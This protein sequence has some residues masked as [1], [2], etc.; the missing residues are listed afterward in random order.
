MQRPAFFQLATT[1]YKLAVSENGSN[2][3]IFG[4]DGGTTSLCLSMLCANVFS[5][6]ALVRSVQKLFPG[7]Q[8]A[9][10]SRIPEAFR[11]LYP[12]TR[13]NFVMLVLEKLVSVCLWRQP[14]L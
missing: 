14:G 4:D 6:N 13:F 3:S 10:R 2:F 9:F 8:F 7:C 11:C 1:I 12:F 5:E